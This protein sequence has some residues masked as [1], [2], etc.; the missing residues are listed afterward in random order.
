MS[1]SRRRCLKNPDHFCD[2]CGEYVFKNCKNLISELVKI[3]YFEGFGM[4]LDKNEKPWVPVCVCKSRVEY[5]RLWECRK[6][7][8]FK[9]GT[10]TIWQE[11]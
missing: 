7:R 5:L 4:L 9:F 8:A 2:I 3:T 1:S 6:R 10:P 11:P